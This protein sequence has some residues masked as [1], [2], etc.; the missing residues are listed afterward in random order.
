M[1]KFYFAAVALTTILLI[2]L[3]N[4]TALLPAA[5]GRLLSPQ[6]GIWQNAENTNKNFD[7]TLHFSNLKGKVEVHIDERLVPHVFAEND[8]DIYFVQGYL[9]AKFRLWQMEFQVYAAGGRLCEILGNNLNGNDILN[10]A[11]RH[12]RRLGMVYAAEIAVKEIEKDPIT[13]ASVDNYTAGINSYIKNLSQSELPLEY[14]L[15]GYKPE[16]W[17]N[18]KTALFLK[19]MSYD[20]AGNENDFEYSNAKKV[21]SVADIEKIFPLIQDTLDPIIPKGTVFAPAAFDMRPP[22]SADS[23]YY[24][25][26]DSINIK[27]TKPNR[28][29]GSNNWAVAGSKT[30]SG[31]PILCN[32]PHLG[33]NLPSLWF[34]MQLHTPNFNAYG[35]SFPGAPSIIIGFNDSCAF[36][37][38][39]AMRDVRDYYEI[40]FK[41]N[42]R[43]A[44]LF[45]GEWKKT[46]FRYERIKI[47]GRPDFVDT[48]AY[49]LFGPVM[50]DK[51]FDEGRNTN[52]KYYAVRWKAH[53]A[54][55]ELKFFNRLNYTKNYN[56]YLAALANLKTP[57]QNC[58]FATKSGDIAIWD[59]GEFPAK[60]KRQG[61]FVMPGTD[62]TY[63]WKGNIPMEQNPHI[64]NPARGFVS[65][66]NQ[67]PADPAAYPYY[68]GGSYPAYRGFVINRYL[69]SM[70][71]ITP[72]DMMKLQTE[73]Y[74]LFAEMAMP[75]Y[76]KYIDENKLSAEEKQYWQIMQVWNLR[77]DAGEKGATV[78][79]MAWDSLESAVWADEYLQANLPLMWPYESTLLEGLLKDT[80]FKYCDNISTSRVEKTADVFVASFKNAVAA[81]KNVA[82]QNKLAWGVFKDTKILHLSRLPQLSRF[83]V[84]I[85]GGTHIINAAK[86]KH[87][88]SWR[89]I[90]HLTNKTEA[91]GIYPGGQSGNPGSKFYDDYINDWAAGKYNVLWMMTAA[92]KNDKRVKWRMT[93]DKG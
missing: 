20:L 2:L 18:L 73:N 84:P 61:D 58:L 62:S 12:F 19:Y 78:F 90:V 51:S 8:D 69:S 37:F 67:Y 43:A 22:A 88:P 64:Y 49:T 72:Q 59:Q 82:A 65:S 40:T 76:K 1:R 71:N 57:G 17:S 83:K 63:L 92:E 5:L 26:T 60:W 80:A 79:S 27:Q 23:L 70:N 3:F 91:Y 13:K 7:E 25:K 16:P 68:L 6:H 54:S 32:D 89:M 45:N 87:G 74:N 28:N 47:K 46:T 42:T 44:Y 77:N 15:L 11:D 14:K 55:N 31:A 86:E 93:F 35:A 41:D 9:H 52:Q 53:E 36:G 50:Y 38:T 56:D 34:E 10:K 33:L 29:N 75:L 21:F 30:K 85:G 4:T 39:N 48:V 66:A 81:L 24:S